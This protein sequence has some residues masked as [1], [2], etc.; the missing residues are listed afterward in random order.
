MAAKK[1]ARKSTPKK[2][3]K[4]KTASR[5]APAKKVAKK[6]ATKKAAKNTVAAKKAPE[7]GKAPTKKSEDKPRKTQAPAAPKAEAKPEKAP[8]S[9]STP[10]RDTGISAQLVNIG[11]I[12]ALRP[13][14]S[15]S[16]KPDQV[17]QAKVHLKDELFETIEEAAR[18][19]A[20]KALEAT[21]INHGKH[22]FKR[23]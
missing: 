12:F 19:V 16:F 6:A 22:G 11:H 4:K 18:A 5:K 2:S 20:E 1:S 3:A 8:A 17:R 15:T 13:R 14:I 9:E 21:S 10:R 23:R 7:K